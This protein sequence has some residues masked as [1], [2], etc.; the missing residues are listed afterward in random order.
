MQRIHP[1]ILSGGMG[2][3][4]WPLSRANRPKQFQPVDGADGPSFLQATVLRHRGECFHDPVVVANSGQADLINTQLAEIGS[5]PT[6]IGE[7]V[8]RNTGPAVLAAALHLH[9]AD[10][11]AMLLVLP[12]DHVIDGDFNDTIAEA[13]EG[14]SEGRIVVFGVTPTYPETGFGYLT[15]GGAIAG[16]PCLRHVEAFV[17]KPDLLRAE[18]MIRQGGSYWAAGIS[19]MRADQII[20]EFARLE[21]DTLVAVE[22]ALAGACIDHGAIHLDETGFSQALQEPTER[23]IFERSRLVAMAPVSVGWNDV[24]AWSAVH[25]I[26]TK[27]DSGN[28]L[29]AEVLSIDTRNSLVRGCGRLI[30]VVGMDDV[31]VVDTPDALLVTNHKNA[32]RVKDAVTALKDDGRIEVQA[33]PLPG[34]ATALDGVDRIVVPPGEAVEQSGAQP[35][36]SVVTVTAGCAGVRVDGLT[37]AAAAGDTLLVRPG[38]RAR[39]INAGDAPLTLVAVTLDETAGHAARDGLL[40]LD[41]DAAL[42]SG[43]DPEDRRV[44]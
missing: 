34:A 39:I 36:G 23:A 30:A 40:V 42:P 33:H 24:G 8:G 26:G 41:G 35:A 1:V 3:R 32:Q 44:A 11:D 16:H 14:A 28:V 10:P 5:R 13:A 15:S 2:S 7:P 4:L 21:P 9:R 29:D 31:I 22:A 18:A 43:P 6:L 12:S 37:R 27:T 20:A 19:L 17:E 25:S 38:D